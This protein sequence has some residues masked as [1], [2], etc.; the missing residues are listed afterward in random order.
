MKNNNAYQ[1]TFNII[2]LI[3]FL[4]L[5]IYFLTL[6]LTSYGIFRDELY[7]LAC[8]DRI[9]FGYVDHPPLSIWI[10]AIWKFIAGDSLF[11]IRIVPAVVSSVVVFLIGLFTLRLGGNRSAV[12]ISTLTFMLTP[13]FLGMSTIYSMNIFD[14]FFWI[15]A[16]YIFLEILNSEN[17]K[18]W[19]VLGI[20]IGLG[21]LNK[22]SILWLAAGIAAG[23]ILTPLRDDLKTKYPYIAAGIAF[24][25]FSPYI[26]WNLFHDFAHLEFMNNAAARKYSGLN[27]L[28]LLFDMLL[29]MNPLSVLIWVPGLIFYFFHRNARP[30]R[31]LGY[32]WVVTLAI[33]FV[34]WHSKAEYIA[35]AY[36]VLFAGGAVMIVNWTARIKRLKYALTV[37]VVVIGIISAPMARPL[38]PVD[39][40]LVYQAILYLKPPNNEGHQLDGLPQFY[41]DMFGWEDLARKISSVYKSLPEE[42]RNKTV[43]YCS[44][45]GKAGAIEYYSRKYHLPKV[46]SPHNNY[47]YWWDEAGKPSTIIIIG[48][49][50]KDHFS[51]LEQVQAAGVHKTRYAIPYEN[52]LNIY[53]GRGFKK[54]LEEIRKSDKI[55][56]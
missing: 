28:S 40:F 8:A 46:V 1:E 44:N 14:L 41:A 54:S 52:N 48:G 12:I 15:L 53:I 25:I 29:I 50:L 3:S 24:L 34:N 23:T 19:Y 18:L 21:L 16:A 55:F 42:E 7:Y 2:L 30:Y 9:D 17:S 27:P 31:P 6:S 13:I 39:K 32:I 11:A 36:M 43:I 45:Y 49:E 56:I 35:A 51:S 4:N 33:L 20:V 38:L 22:T 10:L 47:W 37:P 5:L 26:I